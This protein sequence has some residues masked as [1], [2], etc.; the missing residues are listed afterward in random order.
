M[1]SIIPAT[2]K[3]D[4]PIFQRKIHGKP[5]V[6][7]DSASSSQKPKQV[8][9]TLSDYYEKMHANI[10]RGVYTLSEE[11]TLAYEDA[12]RK[13]ARLINAKFKEIIFTKNTTESINLLA[14]S[15]G[16][17]LKK[18]DEILLTEMEHHANLVPWQQIA[19]RVGAVVKFIKVSKDGELMIDDKLFTNKTKIV[20]VVHIS[21]V[22]GTI[23]PMKDIIAK[24]HKTGAKVI[25]DAAQSIPHMPFDVKTL[26]ADFVAFSSHKMLGPTGIGVLYG[27]Q[28]LLEQMTPFLYGGDMIKEVTLENTTFN[29]LPWKFEAGTPNIAGGIA[30]GTAVEYLMNI[31]MH[32][33]E[34][35]DKE[36]LKY[37]HEKLSKV[38]GITMYGPKDLNKKAGIIAFN[39]EDIHPHDVSSILDT[40]GIAIRGGHHCAMPLMK[41]LGIQ[42]SC[43]LSLYLYN[44]TEDIDALVK[45]LE[46]VRKVFK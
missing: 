30:F 25:I 35:H 24:A 14:Y 15:L 34:Q 43:R 18:G 44:T 36:L 19:K 22:L 7:L 5:L 1:K 39:F 17:E 9:Q 21:N 20:S 12:H 6:Y 42:S 40:E 26:D 23:N 32:N 37:A 4:F 10:H 3:K 46:K 29:D 13:V 38:K 33:I 8:I 16:L 2:I 45:A 31:G 41:A 11:A 27:K 28:E